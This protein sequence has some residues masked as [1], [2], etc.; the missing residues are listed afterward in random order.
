MLA[1]ECQYRCAGGGTRESIC[2]FELRTSRAPLSSSEFRCGDGY[3]GPSRLDGCS[4]AGRLAATAPSRQA[5]DVW[6]WF[7]LFVIHDILHRCRVRIYEISTSAPTRNDASSR[8]SVGDACSHEPPIN[9]SRP[10]RNQPT[11]KLAH[12]HRRPRLDSLFSRGELR[13]KPPS[14][15]H[16]DTV[17]LRDSCVP[18]APR[19]S[20]GSLAHPLLGRT[21]RCGGG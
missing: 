14:A 20:P 18:S 7:N 3:G 4:T 1:G 6:S 19:P 17:W 2:L 10:S 8:S 9:Q 5:G 13:G 21:R 15:C 11:V 16:P 12:A